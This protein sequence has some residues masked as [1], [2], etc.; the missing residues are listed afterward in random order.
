[1]ARAKATPAA[2][3]PERS[4]ID[5]A[6]E[7]LPLI[8]LVIIVL[9]FYGY[10]AYLRKTPWLFGDE[11]EWSQ[12][13]RAIA[14]TGHA[15][16][17]GAPTSFKSLYAFLIAPAWWIKNTH[18]AY[19]TIKYIN[20]VVM[21]AASVPTYLLARMLVSRRSALAAGVLAIAI[22]G[23]AYSTFIIP[24]R[25]PTPGSRSA[26][27]W[28]CAH[29]PHNGGATSWSRSSPCWSQSRCGR[30]SRCS[31]PRSSWRRRPSG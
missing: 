9:T 14:T 13:S 24:S 4:W 21:T 27:G 10:Q 15:A 16:R 18:T 1:M 23:M 3:Q 8:G 20:V 7:A 12:I 29:S 11:D 22:P 2:R 5:G 31:Y 6:L 26:A 17:R 28:S 19:S 25:L 30:S